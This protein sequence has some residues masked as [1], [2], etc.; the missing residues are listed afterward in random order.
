VQR[1]RFTPACSAT[2]LTSSLSVVTSGGQDVGPAGGRRH[3]ARE[4]D[5]FDQVVDMRQM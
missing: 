5:A 3:G 4:P 2:I 1:W